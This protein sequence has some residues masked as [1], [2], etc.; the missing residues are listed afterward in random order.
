MRK[1]FGSSR[2]VLPN[3][4]F[5]PPPKASVNFHSF[6]FIPSRRTV[7]SDTMRETF[8]VSSCHARGSRQPRSTTRTRRVEGARPRYSR[9]KKDDANPVPTTIRS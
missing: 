9:R 5:E 4:Q 7:F 1:S 3:Q 6:S 8:R 2:G